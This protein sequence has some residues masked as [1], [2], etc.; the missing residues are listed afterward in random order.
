MYIGLDRAHF[1]SSTGQCK[2]WD[3]SADGYCRSEGCGMF[4]LKRLS[5]ALAEND[6]ILGVIRGV[7]V[8]Q[9]AHADSITRPHVPTQMDL[10]KKVLSSAGVEPHQVNVVEAHGTGKLLHPYSGSFSQL[11]I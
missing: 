8:N 7:E 1:L 10:F 4:V 6:N 3:A 11:V 9:S 5:D 2:P